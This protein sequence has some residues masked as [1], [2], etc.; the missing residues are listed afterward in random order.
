MDAEDQLIRFGRGA[1]EVIPAGELRKKIAAGKPLRVKAGFD[2]TAPDLHLGHMVLIQ[3]LRYFQDLGHHVLFLIGD[4]TARIGDPTGVSETRPQLTEDQIRE[5]TRTYERQVFKILDPD[6][7]EVVFNN[8][9]LGGLSAADLLRLAALQTVARMLERDDFQI[10]HREGRPIGIHEFLYPI[11]QGYDSVELRADVE[12]G[13]TDQKFNLLVGRE[14]QRAFGQVPQV[15][16]TLPLLVGTDGRRKMSKSLGNHIG[17]DEPPGEIYGKVMSISDELMWSWHE[18]L[19]DVD[20]DALAALKKETESGAR[21]PRDVKAALA[22]ELTARF[23][24]EE[25]ARGAAEEFVARFRRHEVPSDVKKVS[26]PAPDGEGGGGGHWI[27]QLLTGQGLTKSNSE[28]RRLI[29]QG[30][31]RVNG[32]KVSDADL[33]VEAGTHLIQVGKRRFLE[34]TIGG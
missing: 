12:I 33:H 13:G 15:V 31:V 25:A 7:T 8:A 32:E 28:A 11:L 23:H 21:N 14:L 29:G 20:E 18:L 2:P 10:R 4:F 1:A 9:W 34:V 30:G 22:T 17:I 6:K 27:C 3:K 26:I 16:M 24:G 5:N 19:S